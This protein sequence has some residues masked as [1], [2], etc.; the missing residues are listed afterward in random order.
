[1]TLADVVR[2][3][4]FVTDLGRFPEVARAHLEAFG[5]NPPA[6][7]I[8]EIRRLVNPDMMIEIEADA[9]RAPELKAEVGAVAKSRSATKSKL[10]TKSK[11][12]KPNL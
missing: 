1:M 4:V 2:T 10:G 7:T 8:V 5:D 3:R 9:F 11:S 12:S 6:S